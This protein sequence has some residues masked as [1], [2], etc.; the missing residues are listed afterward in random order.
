M[1]ATVC[2]WEIRTICF[3]FHCSLKYENMFAL[4]PESQ[5]QTDWSV[6]TK[7]TRFQFT[8]TRTHRCRT[9]ATS[10]ETTYLICFV[11]WKVKRLFSHRGNQS[12]PWTLNNPSTWKVHSRS[13]RQQL[14]FPNVNKQACCSRAFY[15]IS[16]FICRW[17]LVLSG[18]RGGS[19]TGHHA[20]GGTDSFVTMHFNQ[21]VFL[22][23]PNFI[24]EKMFGPP[25]I[26]YCKYWN[27]IHF[28]QCG[29]DWTKMILKDCNLHCIFSLSRHLFIFYHG[30]GFPTK[31]NSLQSHLL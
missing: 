28:V 19:L 12:T 9:A 4:F 11:L 25:N 7:Q 23:S 20:K 3:G 13:W 18:Q 30:W 27:Q 21:G 8:E 1:V 31:I 26:T 15:L 16:V 14:C 2:C 17:S 22:N 10:P 29:P 24:Q 6:T 5:T